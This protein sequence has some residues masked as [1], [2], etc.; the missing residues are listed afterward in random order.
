MIE[1]NKTI[2]MVSHN[3]TKLIEINDAI[4]K[5]NDNIKNLLKMKIKQKFRDATIGFL[6]LKL[7]CNFDLFKNCNCFFTGLFKFENEVYEVL[8]HEEKDTIT[9]ENKNKKKDFTKIYNETCNEINQIGEIIFFDKI[10]YLIDKEQK[11]ISE[12]E[13]SPISSSIA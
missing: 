10:N 12:T 9:I 5:Q 3:N 4:K 11:L 2:E 7:Y 8:F 13:V 6:Y 1:N